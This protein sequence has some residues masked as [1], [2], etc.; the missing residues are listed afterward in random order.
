MIIT[1]IMKLN[2]VQ[3]LYIVLRPNTN[4][5]KIPGFHRG[6]GSF[7]SQDT[8]PRPTMYHNYILRICL[9]DYSI[10]TLMLNDHK[11]IIMSYNY[12]N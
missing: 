12:D 3:G 1:E 11:A 9:K 2:I 7:Q 10:I 6:G 5:R 8:T 4:S